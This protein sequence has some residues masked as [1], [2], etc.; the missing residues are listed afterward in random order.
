MS[1]S[2]PLATYIE[3]SYVYTIPESRLLLRRNNRFKTNLESPPFLEAIVGTH[4]VDSR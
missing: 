2:L 3:Y 1:F 4:I